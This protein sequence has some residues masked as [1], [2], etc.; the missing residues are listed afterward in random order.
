MEKKSVNNAGT[1]SHFQIVLR[2]N[3][4]YEVWGKK[5]TVQEYQ[6]AQH[7]W[8]SVKNGKG[9]QTTIIQWSLY[10]EC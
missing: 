10:H 7:I 4:K 1:L 3:E 2:Q 6:G 9:M 8:N 5:E